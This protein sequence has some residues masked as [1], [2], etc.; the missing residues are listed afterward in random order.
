MKVKLSINDEPIA[1]YLNIDPSPVI[2]PEYE[3]SYQIVRSN[4][5]D[6]D[7][8]L[9]NSECDEIIVYNVLSN[10]ACHQMYKLL[11]TIIAKLSHNGKIIIYDTEL[12]S[13]VKNY[14]NGKIT[15]PELN[16]ALFGDRSNPWRI[17]NGVISLTEVMEIL[18]DLHLT[19][20][21]ISFIEPHTFIITGL[22]P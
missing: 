9:F 7:T 8:I 3:A 5:F 2:T 12:M 13:L 22:R 18:T 20:K 14:I 10:M 6:L 11:E 17:K 16:V 4:F 21:E 19:I 15:T 1:G